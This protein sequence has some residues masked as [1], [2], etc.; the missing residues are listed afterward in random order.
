MFEFPG[1]LAQNIVQHPDPQTSNPKPSSQIPKET[2]LLHTQ[3]HQD[4]VA[5]MGSSLASYFMVFHGLLSNRLQTAVDLCR[6]A[7]SADRGGSSAGPSASSGHG[8]QQG[9][10]SSNARTSASFEGLCKELADSCAG[11]QH[12]YMHAQVGVGLERSQRVMHV[13]WVSETWNKPHHRQRCIPLTLSRQILV[14]HRT[15]ITHLTHVQCRMRYTK[16]LKS[17]PSHARFSQIGLLPTSTVTLF[18]T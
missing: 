13:L 6:T 8:Q 7:H 5:N 3:G 9:P 4:E 10:A 14:E 11:S 18:S 2:H 16:S 15:Q 1:A 12:T 17:R